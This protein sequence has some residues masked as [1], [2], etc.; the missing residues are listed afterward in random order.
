MAKAKIISEQNTVRLNQFM[1]DEIE[2]LDAEIAIIS[3]ETEHEKQG[4]QKKS[5]L[6]RLND[7]CRIIYAKRK[8]FHDC[9][10]EIH[11]NITEIEI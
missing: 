5:T 9:L 11:R 1:L 2:R 8:V 10:C 6:Q 4:R 3:A 7:Q